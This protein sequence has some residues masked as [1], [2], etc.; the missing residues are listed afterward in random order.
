M[1]RWIVIVFLALGSLG[2]TT[3][4]PG[5]SAT[6]NQKQEEREEK[7]VKIK[8]KECPK[9][10][11]DTIRREAQGVDITEVDR[12]ERDGVFVYEVDAV[13]DGTNYEIVVAADGKLISKKID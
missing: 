1:T 6:S 10:V 4:R 13:I 3:V 7:E 9:A 2:M 5:P 12:E 11:Q 8:F